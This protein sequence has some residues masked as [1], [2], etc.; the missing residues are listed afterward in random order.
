[1][2]K[3]LSLTLTGL[4]VFV[5]LAELANG[6]SVDDM[7]DKMIKAQGG[8]AKLEAVK[9]AVISGTFEMAATGMNGDWTLK[10]LMS[11]ETVI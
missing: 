4:L 5:F 7:L 9:D 10:V 11:A 2:K 6:Q 1:M 8:R 3:T